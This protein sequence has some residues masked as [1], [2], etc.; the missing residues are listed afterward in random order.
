VGGN[1]H[2]PHAPQAVLRQPRKN[3]RKR[4]NSRLGVGKLA[5]V[6]DA[7]RPRALRLI[8]LLSRPGFH[9]FLTGAL[10]VLGFVLAHA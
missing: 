3:R 5:A 4:R 9:L 10:M 6:S 1:P 2:K 7:L 8:R